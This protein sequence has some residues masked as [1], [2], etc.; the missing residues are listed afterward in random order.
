MIRPIV[1]EK[2]RLKL[3]S[4]P[5]TNPDIAA[6][7]VTDLIN[8]AEYHKQNNPV[9]CAGLAANQIGQ[10]TRIIVIAYNGDWLPMINP[11]WE[12]RGDQRGSAREGCLSRPG[13]RPIVKRYKRI[14]VVYNDLDGKIVKRKFGGFCARVIQ[15]EVDHLNGVYI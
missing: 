2:A 1:I 12:G 4:E 14:K 7:V 10:L 13:K 11:E 3:L 9:G 8:T 5:V 6:S 15:H